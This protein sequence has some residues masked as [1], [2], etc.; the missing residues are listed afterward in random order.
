MLC[1]VH[2]IFKV[3]C[4]VLQCVVVCCS[5]LR[6]VAEN[7]RVLSCVF[8]SVLQ[9]VAVCCNMLHLKHGISKVETIGDGC[10]MAAGLIDEDGIVKNDKNNARRALAISQVCCSVMQCGAVWC[11]V[12][13][14]VAVCCNVL[15]R[16]VACCSVVQCGA[17]WCSVLQCV[18]VCCNVLW[19]VAV[20]CC[21]EYL[22]AELRLKLDHVTAPIRATKRAAEIDF[23]LCSWNQEIS[24]F[25]I[26][27]LGSPYISEV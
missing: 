9:C 6:C 7:M 17:V 5:A 2:G 22:R 1:L 16:V 15:W 26:A 24:R 25:T 8:C 12:V 23:I 4:S 19:R 10:V 20:C 21:T 27:T 18:A 14:C 11:S 13:Q 3:C